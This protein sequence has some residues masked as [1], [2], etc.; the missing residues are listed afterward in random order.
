MKGS[1]WHHGYFKRQIVFV[2]KNEGI[3]K[4]M[5]L[6]HVIIAFWGDVVLKKWF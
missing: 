5:I 6:K 1:L 3:L 2:Q 4:K